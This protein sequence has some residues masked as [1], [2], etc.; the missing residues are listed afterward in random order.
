MS[1]RDDLED[2]SPK[3]KKQILERD[4][5]QCVICGMGKKERVE[6]HIDHIKPKDL[7][8]KATLENGQTLCSK[9]N[10]LKKNLKQTET[11]KKMFLRMLE[12][13][14]E[15]NQQE[16]IDFLEDVLEVYEKH[17]INGHIV[18]KKD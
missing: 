7:G 17:N 13:T 14:K 16:L 5:Y 4:N 12:S 18:W 10:F 2:F 8:G 6:L 3:L 1:L 15:S 9:H 11:G